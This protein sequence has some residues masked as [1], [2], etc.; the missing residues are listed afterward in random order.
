MTKDTQNANN[1]L[2]VWL[3]L[4]SALVS[5]KQSINKSN[6]NI[7]PTDTTVDMTTLKNYWKS[8][9]NMKNILQCKGIEKSTTCWLTL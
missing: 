4:L 7:I 8:N 3:G 5:E 2:N 6:K 9:S 1:L